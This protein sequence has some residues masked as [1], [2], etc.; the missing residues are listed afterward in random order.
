MNIT[1]E[2]N[3]LE[4]LQSSI[5]KIIQ[6]LHIKHSGNRI[7]KQEVHCVCDTNM[8]NYYDWLEYLTN[9]SKREELIQLGVNYATNYLVEHC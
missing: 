7:I 9:R 1:P 6:H 3:L 4:F 2:Y 8:S 5:Y